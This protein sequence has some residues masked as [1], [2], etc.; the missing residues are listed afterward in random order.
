MRYGKWKRQNLCECGGVPIHYRRGA[1]FEPLDVRIYCSNCRKTTEF[2]STY[3]WDDKRIREA[4]E[5]IKNVATAEK[6]ET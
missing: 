3:V 1:P 2:F 4:W 5:K 6:N